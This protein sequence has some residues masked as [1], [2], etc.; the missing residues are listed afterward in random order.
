M[1]KVTFHVRWTIP[2]ST[3]SC[4]VQH[5]ADHEQQ[6]AHR[7]ARETSATTFYQNAMFFWFIYNL[8]FFLGASKLSGSCICSL[9]FASYIL[10]FFLLK[11]LKFSFA[12]STGQYFVFWVHLFPESRTACCKCGLMQLTQRNQISV[13]SC[14]T[15]QVLWNVSCKSAYFVFVTW[16]IIFLFK[17]CN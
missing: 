4:S 14:I 6:K 13:E 17:I 3:E 7:L 8:C 16:Y 15:P 12:R 2:V 10:S 11:F 1:W 5:T 9:L